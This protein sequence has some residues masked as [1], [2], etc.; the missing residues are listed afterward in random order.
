MPKSHVAFF[1]PALFLVLP[2]CSGGVES[3][4][5]PAPT[6]ASTEQPPPS[7][8]P[9]KPD[10]P[11]VVDPDLEPST[12]A[13]TEW[14]A[15]VQ[16]AISKTGRILVS[17]I[18]L[19]SGGASIDY[20]ISSDGGKTFGDTYKVKATSPVLGDPVAAALD[21]GSFLVGGL[22][23][24][25]TGISSCSEVSIFVSKIGPNTEEATVVT[26]AA[27]PGNAFID[28]PWMQV[29]D[30]GV[31]L[32]GVSDDTSTAKLTVWRTTDSGTTWDARDLPLSAGQAAI[33]RFCSGDR[34][35]LWAHYYGGSSS[36]YSTLVWA[37][38]ATDTWTGHEVAP[39]SPAHADAYVT[40]ACTANDKIVYDVLGSMD[41][42]AFGS[43]SESKTPLYK[44]LRIVSS[45]DAG[46]TWKDVGSIADADSLYLLPQILVEPDG[47]I[48]VTYSRGAVEGGDATMELRH[49]TDGGKTFGAPKILAKD[50]RLIADRGSKKWTGDY[51]AIVMGPNGPVVAFADNSLSTTQVR[52]SV[53]RL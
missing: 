52:V 13:S 2:A 30:A 48:D 41:D 21:D 8:P 11:P 18:G 32:I 15:E 26:P 49:S 10:E 28:H 22:E 38:A 6:T 12:L 24:T 37:D 4:P 34:T 31:F 25:C 33:P 47:S 43:E 7:K 20:A 23:G 36:S 46:V 35:R 45:D 16:M 27:E 19:S 29:T 42:G 53:P 17:W 5:P 50:Q 1:A 40:G 39:E 44:D 9:A 14:G 3:A 51:T